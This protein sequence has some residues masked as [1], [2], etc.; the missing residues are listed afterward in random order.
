[1]EFSLNILPKPIIP[2]SQESL[3]TA[4]R[5]L[6]SIKFY[7]LEIPIVDP[8]EAA[9]PQRLRPGT[10]IELQHQPSSVMKLVKD[11]NGNLTVP[12]R[13]KH[14]KVERAVY[15]FY[16]TDPEGVVNGVYYGQ[17]KNVKGR[18]SVYKSRFKKAHAGEK[19]RKVEE[20]IAGAKN[21]YWGVVTVPSTEDSMDRHERAQI[22]QA[23]LS[24]DEGVELLNTQVGRYVL[25][26]FST[27]SPVKENQPPV[28]NLATTP[29]RRRL[30]FGVD[31]AASAPVS[32][33]ECPSVD[34]ASQ[35]V[36]G[37]PSDRPTQD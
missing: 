10:H 32:V 18:L 9:S 34:E 17:A 20:K 2:I 14:V 27:P 15:A 30:N 21:V 35:S 26:S 37:T 1:M 25:G 28:G 13:G 24:A 31:P 23:I 8:E 4:P 22:Q 16:I 36:A 29:A 3:P 7:N 12:M 19:C 5:E 11:R 33:T 6:K